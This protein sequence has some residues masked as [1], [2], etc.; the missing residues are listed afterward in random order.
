MGGFN[1]KKRDEIKTFMTEQTDEMVRKYKERSE[2][3]DRRA[4]F[5]GTSNETEILHDA[6]GE[7]RWLPISA[8]RGD[9]EGIKAVRDQLWAEGIALFEQHGVMW[10]AAHELAAPQHEK[11]KESDTWEEAIGEFIEEQIETWNGQF[12]AADIAISALGF[13]DVGRISRADEMRIGRVLRRMGY[14]N[15]LLRV[16]GKRVRRWVKED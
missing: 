7:R 5:I 3:T 8:S 6:T 11:F 13:Q 10:Q 12:T 14:E 9:I 1:G 15:R 4:V 16:N 2:R